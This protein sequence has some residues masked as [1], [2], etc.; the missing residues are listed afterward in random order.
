MLAM[1]YVAVFALSFVCSYPLA[2]P[3]SISSSAYDLSIYIHTAELM[4]VS[5]W[6][7]DVAVQIS[8]ISSKACTRWA[9]SL[10]P[11]KRQ[12]I[13]EENRIKF[14]WC[15]KGTSLLP[16]QVY[17]SMLFQFGISVFFYIRIS[18]TPPT[19]QIPHGWLEPAKHMLYLFKQQEIMANKSGH[20]HP[21]L[22]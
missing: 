2:V 19:M 17:G 22:S 16:P 4:M 11:L 6:T 21:V 15:W 8:C 20:P 12:Y 7:S 5:F 1:I 10:H 3:S 9:A 14:I 13:Y 18:Q